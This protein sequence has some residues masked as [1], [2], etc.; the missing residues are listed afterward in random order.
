MWNLVKPNE[1]IHNSIKDINLRGYNPE[2]SLTGEFAWKLANDE[3]RPLSVSDIADR[4]CPTRR[5]LYFRKGVNRLSRRMRQNAETLGSKAGTLVEKYLIN[6][7]ITP[8]TIETP[9]YSDIINISDKN[10]QSFMNEANIVRTIKQL[11]ELE[12]DIEVKENGNTEW[13]QELL[14]NNGRAEFALSYLNGILKENLSVLEDDFLIGDNAKI[15]VNSSFRESKVK[16]IGINLPAT[17][18]FIIPKY[19]IIGDIKTGIEFKDHFQLTCAG[20]ALAYESVYGNGHEIDWGV[21]YFFPTRTPSLFRRSITFAQ[22]YIFPID[23]YL[24]IEFLEKRDEA[25][26]IISNQKA[27]KLPVDKVHCHYCR[28]FNHCFKEN[29]IV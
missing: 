19:R 25:Y 8:N 9:K 23:D 13:L 12:K 26:R 10:Y 18:D 1:Q 24:R 3:I 27:P 11:K 29:K 7:V 20:Y 15:D 17:P 5:D 6:V 22:V 14:K 16:K 28:F 2:I 4:Y 21:I